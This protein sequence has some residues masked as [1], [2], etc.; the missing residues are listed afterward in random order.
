RSKRLKG[1]KLVRT[2]LGSPDASGRASPKPIKGSEW[3]L[4]CDVVIEAIG[5]KPAAESTRWYPRVK[6]DDHQLIK[7]NAK[8]GQTSV[9]GVFAGGDIV[10]G[11]GLVVQAVS[12]GKVA[13]RAIK[14]FLNP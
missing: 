4:D 3:V 10:R 11:P 6:V 12:D 2:R 7:S 14:Q 9:K 5:N 1:V 8:T 13:A